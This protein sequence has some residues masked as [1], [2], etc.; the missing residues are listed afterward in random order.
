MGVIINSIPKND[1]LSH[2]TYCVFTTHRNPVYSYLFGYAILFKYNWHPNTKHCAQRKCNFR[3][4]NALLH[5]IAIYSIEFPIFDVPLIWKFNKN[6]PWDM[7][8]GKLFG[9]KSI[10]PFCVY[11]CAQW[12]CAL[13]FVLRHGNPT[14]LWLSFVYCEQRKFC[15]PARYVILRV[16]TT[17]NGLSYNLFA[18][19]FV[20]NCQFG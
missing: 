5:P 6:T 11:E 1:L 3:F 14:C 8:D 17:L 16:T 4:E 18:I 12:L 15:L 2:W 9:R 10:L 20:A 19:Y 13:L 7:E